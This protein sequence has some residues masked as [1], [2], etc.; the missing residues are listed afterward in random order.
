[1]KRRRYANGPSRRTIMHGAALGMG[2]LVLPRLARGQEASSRR[3]LFVFCDGGWD[4][5]TVFVPYSDL[6]VGLPL[7]ADSTVEEIGALRFVD[8]P[9]RP[10]VRS[11]FE[12]WHDRTCILNGF[13]VRSI[14]HERC[15]QLVLTG[16][17]DA[18]VDDWPTL[19]AAAATDDP[20]LPALV[21]SGPSFSA[22]HGNA[23][24]RLGESGQLSGLVDG[25]S[26]ELAG[27]SALSGEAG[28]AV[29]RY[30]QGRAQA[31][32]DAAATERDLRF[33][34]RYHGA[35]EDGVALGELSGDLDLSA[36]TSKR[37]VEQLSPA[38]D[39]LEQG[40]SRC[41]LS[42]NLGVNDMGYD[43]HSDNAFLQ[44]IHQDQLF[45]DLADLM[46]ELESRTGTSGQPLSEETVV[47]VFSEMGRNPQI[48]GQDGRDH[49]TWTSAM[50]VGA[51][52][53][54]GV[55]GGF[56]DSVL[57]LPVDLSTGLADAD[58]VQLRASHLGATL[59]ALGGLDPSELL[60]GYDPVSAVW[61]G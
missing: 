50:I 37:F 51:P 10:F 27:V 21:V 12:S 26:L 58:G 31:F 45:S 42:R 17:A 16:R 9:A 11:F 15:R 49:W 8:S 55:V 53:R 48:N 3:F 14:V 23:V 13:E 46:A 47:V 61:G 43:S 20:L 44:S 24:V 59:L 25:S 6:D 34:E 5:S 41:V 4:Q 1:M 60:P 30:L 57:G 28:T 18:A 36:D 19:L 35:L 2:G 33:G 32:V 29:D 54:G 39:A 56:D 22:D 38:L 52:V 7:E 40:L